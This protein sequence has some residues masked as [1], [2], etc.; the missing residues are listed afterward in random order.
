MK[1]DYPL[2][3]KSFQKTYDFG[4][5]HKGVDLKANSGT[6]VVAIADGE[7][8]KSDNSDA[9][10]YGGQILL[11]HK[12]DGET[13]YSRYAH[14]K[15]YYPKVNTVVRKGDVIG[16]SG[17]G[18][19][20]KNK[21]FATGPHLHFEL[22]DGLSNPMDPEPFLTGASVLGA[23]SGDS[24]KDKEEDKDKDQYNKSEE[25]SIPT[26][27]MKAFYKGYGPA[28]LFAAVPGLSQ[29]KE[30]EIPKP[31]ME[32]IDRIKELLK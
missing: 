15:E 4:R 11:K 19:D 9:N 14:L 16:K 1:I 5:K 21:G 10:G 2:Q 3:N 7:V 23:T 6:P 17:G 20:D 27:I 22:M 24:S 31:I 8:M 25:E 28:S 13:Y 12:I 29:P 26:K 18:T 30:S 32:E